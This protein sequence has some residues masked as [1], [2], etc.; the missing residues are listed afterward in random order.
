[1]ENLEN[2]STE[3]ID[4]IQKKSVDNY[5]HLKIAGIE[6]THCA[7]EAHYIVDQVIE[8]SSNHLLEN[9]E[10]V[11]NITWLTVKDFSVENGIKKIHEFIKVLNCFIDLF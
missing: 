8:S 11:P 2:I 4:D 1:M 9:N 6:L 3:Y 5:E 7:K 10:E